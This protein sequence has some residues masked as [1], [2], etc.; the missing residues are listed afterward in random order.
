MAKKKKLLYKGIRIQV[1]KEQKNKHSQIVSHSSPL[2]KKVEREK[3]RDFKEN[4]IKQTT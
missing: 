4:Q 2:E 3:E 1:S